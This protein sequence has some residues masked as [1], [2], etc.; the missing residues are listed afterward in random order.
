MLRNAREHKARIQ[1]IR[2]VGAIRDVLE[3]RDR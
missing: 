2:G 3:I 1:P